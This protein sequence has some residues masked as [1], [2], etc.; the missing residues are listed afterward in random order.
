[1]T[2]RKQNANDHTRQRRIQHQAPPKR[3]VSSLSAT[4]LERK[5]AN[6]REAQ[7]L[8]RQRTKDRIDSLEQEIADL[9]QENEQLHRCLRQRSLRETE[10][11]HKRNNLDT[12]TASWNCSK[13]AHT[14]RGQEASSQRES[15]NH[16]FG[17]PIFILID[18]QLF[19]DL[20][21]TSHLDITHPYRQFRSQ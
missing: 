17:H 3:S 2:A 14:A 18:E 11:L 20:A 7:R 4:Q 9:K 21:I 15:R 8:I 5:R 1:M 16:I 6:D 12:G 13:I 19:Q 10:I